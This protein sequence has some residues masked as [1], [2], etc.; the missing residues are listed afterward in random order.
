[1]AVFVWV[2]EGFPKGATKVLEEPKGVDALVKGVIGIAVGW[3]IGGVAVA[4]GVKTT[5][6]ENV[7][8][9]LATELTVGV[10]SAFASEG[11]T[12]ALTGAG[13]FDI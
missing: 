1:M 3:S 9:E 5:T 10:A 6:D 2:T 11:V 12:T 13:A 4:A 8:T 7:F